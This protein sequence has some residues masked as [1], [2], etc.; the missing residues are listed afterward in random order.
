MEGGTAPPPP[1]PSPPPPPGPLLVDA[2]WKN[3]WGPRLVLPI[4][5]ETADRAREMRYSARAAN[6]ISRACSTTT[7]DE[8]LFT[9]T[10]GEMRIRRSDFFLSLSLFFFFLSLRFFFL[11]FPELLFPRRAHPRLRFK[12]NWKSVM[13]RIRSFLLFRKG[14]NYH[15]RILHRFFRS[16][17]IYRHFCHRSDELK[18]AREINITSGHHIYICIYGWTR[19]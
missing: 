3:G 9:N 12:G 7:F 13:I 18:I 14:G 4:S 5:L 10:E 15:R 11:S 1:L 2:A 8:L 19:D 17:A 6:T 16:I